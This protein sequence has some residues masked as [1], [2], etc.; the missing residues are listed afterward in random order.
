MPLVS[1]VTTVRGKICTF[2][3][4]CCKFCNNLVI[5]VVINTAIYVV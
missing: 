1:I 3:R 5:Y 4:D 2:N